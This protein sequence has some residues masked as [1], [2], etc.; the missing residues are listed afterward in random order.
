MERVAFGDQHPDI[1][2]YPRATLHEMARPH[3]AAEKKQ[4]Q[5][6]K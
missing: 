6:I 1:I 4:Q 5:I 2:L 3:A